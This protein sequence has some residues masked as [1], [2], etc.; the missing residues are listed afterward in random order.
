MQTLRRYFSSLVWYRRCWM[1][2]RWEEKKTPSFF[3]QNENSGPWINSR[4]MALPA[5]SVYL[6]VLSLSLSLSI[7][8]SHTHT[9]FLASY[10]IKKEKPVSKSWIPMSE[11]PGCLYNSQT[12]KILLIF[13]YLI[14]NFS[15]KSYKLRGAVVAVLVV[16]G[17]A[18]QSES[19]KLLVCIPLDAGLFFSFVSPFKLPIINN[20]VSLFRSLL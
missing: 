15:V 17:L 16:W 13:N 14:I 19:W 2:Y 4:L 9:H 12:L 7:Y 18:H 20:V 6:C 10:L 5:S 3:S 8:L 11:E 1:N